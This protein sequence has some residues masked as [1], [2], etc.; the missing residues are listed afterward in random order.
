[1]NSGL[2]L[3]IFRSSLH[4]GPG[5]RTTVFLKGCPLRCIWCH[6]P[7]SQ[8]FAPELYFLETK[9]TQCGACV[10]ACPHGCHAL[11]Q[12]R[13][14]I[15]RR[16]CTQC[17]ACVAA[18]PVGALEIK[19]RRMTVDEVL[20]EVEKDRPYYDSSGGGMTLS[21]G[22]PLAQFAF[23]LAL[24]KGARARGIHTCVETSGYAESSRL[25]E[26]AA[27]VDLFLF[28]YKATGEPLHRNLTGVPGRVIRENLDLLQTLGARIILRCPLVPGINDGDA[29]LAEIARLALEHPA[30]EQVEIMPFH[31]MYRAKAERIGRTAPAAGETDAT[32]ADKQR[33]LEAI[34][35]AGCDRVTV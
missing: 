35:R 8:A 15:D 9:C 3:D 23:S 26:L 18:C 34:R 10:T 13:H 2:V 27:C 24:L 4:D 32:E 22:E 31:A 30:V 11:R 17:G 20:A 28:D 6:N 1:M 21:G 16:P 19:G 12:G 5:I 7:E 29:H 33:W 14:E 25:R